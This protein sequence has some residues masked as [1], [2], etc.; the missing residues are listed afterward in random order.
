MC[1]LHLLKH[2][3]FLS[4]FKFCKQYW[5]TFLFKKHYLQ[6]YSHFILDIQVQI[7]SF[8][9]ML[10]KSRFWLNWRDKNVWIVSIK[11]KRISVIYQFNKIFSNKS[12]ENFSRNSIRISFFESVRSRFPILNV[13]SPVFA[14][15]FIGSVHFAIYR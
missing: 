10:E 7:S 3:S 11:S 14:A 2:I 8:Y 13:Q 15:Q 6:C 9:H 12:G 1:N 5:L 4:Y